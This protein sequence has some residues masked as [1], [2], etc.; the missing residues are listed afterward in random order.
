MKRGIHK[1][2]LPGIWSGVGGHCEPE[3]LNDPLATCLREIFEETGIT[4]ENIFNLELRYIIIRR[5]GDTIR[6]SYIYFGETDV[7]DITDTDE[8]T[9]HWIPQADLLNREFSQ[10]FAAMLQHFT[11]TPDHAHRV[12]VGI[13]GNPHS[14]FG[15]TWSVVEDFA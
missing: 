1:K 4:K 13:A 11:T 7:A 3:E 15:M 10:T 5:A 6:Q 9:L 12:I 8:G 14:A 2:L